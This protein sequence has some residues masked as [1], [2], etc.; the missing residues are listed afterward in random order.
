MRTTAL[1]LFILLLSSCCNSSGEN[2]NKT[3]FTYNESNGISS[4]D[5]AFSRNLENM[6]AV[7][8]LFDGLV[9][10]DSSLQVEP[11][12]AES[13]QVLDS[14]RRYVFS[15]RDDV[16]WH[17][18]EHF[19]KD[20]TRKVVAA[21]FV[22]SIERILN[23]KT[24]SPG[25]WVFDPIAP[26]GV[27]AIDEQTLEIRLSHP[28]PPFLSMLAMQYCNVVP[29]EIVEH[30]GE[31]FRSNPIGCGPFKMAFW[32]ENVALVYHR[33]EDFWQK[34]SNGDEL[35]HLDAI[36]IDFVR[37]MSAEFTG[38]IKGQYDFM[39]GIHPAYKDELLTPTG[40]LNAGFEDDII[41]Q[42]TPFIKTDYIGIL[43]D[44]ELELSS[45]HPLS[46][47]LVR[48]A[49]NHAVNRDQMVRYLR[50]NAVISADNGFIPK[51][52]PGHREKA[53]YRY[54]YS[55]A[56]AKEL[57]KEAGHEN[58]EGLG[59]ITLSTTSDYV[60]LSEF[61]QF[62]KMFFIFNYIK[63]PRNLKF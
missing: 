12:I 7:N 10:L 5:P 18:S 33:N 40:V 3:V 48:R 42:K 53:A 61:L 49:L 24:A 47:S 45:N 29:R 55:I 4:L 19:G 11:L 54:Y 44:T 28:F 46:K 1:F 56:K 37:D 25:K 9:E 8:Q 22:Y 26:N 36:K 6:W 50:N 51:G 62:H 16:Y 59:T 38:L 21:D 39:S 30:Y 20:S 63:Y 43:V 13:W 60:D 27:S 57:L 58:G 17:K 35:P 23:P 32:M 34:D 52:L 31:D 41:F 15:L 14:G 2:V